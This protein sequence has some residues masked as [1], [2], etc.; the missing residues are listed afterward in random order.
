MKINEY[1]QMMAY[2]IKPDKKPVTPKSK[3]KKSTREAYKEYL[4]IRPFLDAESQMFIEK[5][6]GFAMGG[7][8]E[9][10]KRGLVDE[11]GSY[12]GEK[13]LKTYAP[14][15]VRLEDMKIGD[16]KGQP[17]Y[18]VRLTR[19]TEDGKK[20]KINK[21]FTNYKDAE[22]AYY[23]FDKKYPRII[24]NPDDLEKL[25]PKF[26]ALINKPK[27]YPS[28]ASI[29][30]KLEIDKGVFNTLLNLYEKEG[31]VLP[32]NR[33]PGIQTTLAGGKRQQ[34]IDAYKTNKNLNIQDLA[35]KFKVDRTTVRRTLKDAGLR[36]PSEFQN[37]SDPEKK[38]KAKY[39][40]GELKKISVPAYEQ[41]LRG[42]KYVSLHHGDSKRFNVTT[43]TLGYAP[44]RVN[45]FLL[46]KIEKYLNNLYD[47]REALLKNKP[48]DLVE[49]LE[50]INT[51]GLNAVSAPEVKGYL[52][53]KIMDPITYKM[54]DF[55]M[56][57]KTTIDPADLLK[58]KN[59]KDLSAFDK[60]LIE[61]NR[62]EVKASQRGATLPKTV[63]YGPKTGPMPG[64]GT[65]STYGSQAQKIIQNVE[66]MAENTLAALGCPGK[67]TGGRIGFQTGATPT[68]QCIAR[69]AEKIN[70]GNIKPGAEARN[71]TQFLKGAYKLGRNVVK[72]GVIPEAMYVTGES[73]FRMGLGDT[74]EEAF[75]RAT[76]F[77]RPG[78]QTEKANILRDIRTLNPEI[79]SIIVGANDYKKAV[80][81]LKNTIT[82]RDQNQAVLDDSE[83]GYTSN[84]NSRRQLAI[85]EQKVKKAQ[86]DLR[87]RFQPEAVT[88]FAAMKEA[89]SQDI[90][91]SQAF[92]PKFVQKAR[93]SQ[94]DSD[95]ETI[96]AP[97]IKQKKIAAPMLTI[98]DLAFSTGLDRDTLDTYRTLSPDINKAVLEEL[99]SSGRANLANRERLFGTSGLFFGQPISQKP[100]Y[101]F[102]GGG[103]AKLA[104]K[105]SGPPPE[106]GPTPQGL[107]FL[108]KRGR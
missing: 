56:D 18:E 63:V 25:L 76:D 17:R 11:P 10:P 33:F 13:I 84:I 99:F 91:K 90:A 92:F 16:K 75:N 80:E 35:T 3:P 12:S 101:D 9:T 51:K 48:K 8:V 29:I 7:S 96:A 43:R 14:G 79:A 85:D 67:A 55:G 83:F 95:I 54:S 66:K 89:E 59:I 36:D 1:N 106:S 81:N 27:K 52:N 73:L 2:L 69:G 21:K 105:S 4:E 37:I 62:K 104:G 57:I 38:T 6:L 39:R 46:P 58:G 78:D 5:E 30:K 42:N 71:A 15:F 60:D 31:N 107:D 41:K 72:F 45:T 26:K 32:K 108:M 24:R 44:P 61:L 40:Y 64:K 87:A 82:Q 94:I 34:I 28:Q 20:F 86:E 103:I 100:A 77:L 49:K 19:T 53:F 47:Q 70:F 65:K 102:A 50:L 93:D 74:K 23:S 22:K 97:E 88:D 98:D 68:A